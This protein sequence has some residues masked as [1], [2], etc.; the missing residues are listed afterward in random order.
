MMITLVKI[1][2]EKILLSMKTEMHG[3]RIGLMWNISMLQRVY[4]MMTF[5]DDRRTVC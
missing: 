1:F 5:F 2:P 4:M 3:S